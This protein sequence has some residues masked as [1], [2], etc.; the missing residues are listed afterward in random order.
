[1]IILE[2][3]E[4]NN[5][6]IVNKIAGGMSVLQPELAFSIEMRVALFTPNTLFS[7][8][9]R[10]KE[11]YSYGVASRNPWL[12]AFLNLIFVNNVCLFMGDNNHDH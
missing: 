12:K 9:F 11:K 8:N 5:K 6:P 4:S 1:M 3:I 2:I 7:F 10:S